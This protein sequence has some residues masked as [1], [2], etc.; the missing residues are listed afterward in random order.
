MKLLVLALIDTEY[1][2]LLRKMNAQFA[3]LR[4]RLPHTRCYIIGDGKPEQMRG[5][6]FTY[7]HA[8][9]LEDKIACCYNLSESL[10]PDLVYF[11]YPGAYE[12]LLRYVSAFPNVVFEHNTIEGKEYTGISKDREL[13]LGPQIISAAAGVI[14][15][16]REIAEYERERSRPDLPIFVLPNSLDT[17]PEEE[18]DERPP[19][20]PGMALHMIMAAR[21]DSWHGVERIIEGIAQS[22]TRSK[23]VLHLVG[24][25]PALAKYHR[26]V[27]EH[28][29]SKQVIFHG[30]LD[31]A[32]L[33]KIYAQCHLAFGAIA[34]ARK[35]LRE[36]CAIKAREYCAM[37][38]PFVLAGSD[39]DFQMDLPFVH[40][41]PNDDAPVVM[42]D[43]YTFALE[44]LS[45]PAA[46]HA[47]RAFAQKRLTWD[48]RSEDW[49]NFLRSVA[50]TAAKKITSP[51]L[52][53]LFSIVIPCY[54]QAHFLSEAVAS[55]HAQNF[56]DL[57]VIIVNDGSPDNTSEVARQ[58]MA[59]Y[60]DMVIRVLEQEN[61]G[62]SEARNS[63]IRE[64]KA[65]WILCVDSD[66][67][68]A[69]GF[70]VA[71][72]AAIDETPQ[73]SALGGMLREFGA[74][75]SDWRY[76]LFKGSLSFSNSLPASV[77]FRRSLWEAVGGYDPSNP[78]GLE[79]W[80][81][82]LKSMVF[83]WLPR[84]LSK[85]QYWYRIHHKTS[86]FDKVK[87]HWN[88]V[89]AL[90][91]TML[92]GNYSS[93]TVLAAHTILLNMSDANQQRIKAK[94]ER[95]PE[96][97]LPWFWLG[98]YHE[99]QNE[100]EAALSC[101]LR[102]QHLD[103]MALPHP[104]GPELQ[105]QIHYRLYGLYL[106]MNFGKKAQLSR[107][108]CEELKPELKAPLAE[109]D[110]IIALATSAQKATKRV[111]LMGEFFWPSLG[112]IETFLEH[113][114][115]YL[116]QNGYE[117][118]VATRTRPG[119]QSLEHRGMRIHEFPHYMNL[120]SGL[121]GGL[122][123]FDCLLR[124]CGFSHVI[125]LSHIDPWSMYLC[126]MPHP[127]PK[128]IFLP[129]LQNYKDFIKDQSLAE[130]VRLI[131]QA[132]HVC[133][134]MES[135]LDRQLLEL[136]GIKSHFVPHMVPAL[137]SGYQF[138]KSFGLAADI[139]LF[140]NV[141]NFWP[142]KNHLGLIKTLKT[143]QGDWRLVMIGSPHD[144]RCLA[145]VQKAIEGD[146]RFML[147]ERQPRDVTAA[148][149]READTVLLGSWYEGCPLTILEAMS[150]GTP[151]LATPEC[152]S[153]VDQAGG[154]VANLERFPLLLTEIV[155]DESVKAA[156][157]QLG[158]RHWKAC[159]SPEAVLPAFIDLLE[160]DGAHMPDLRMPPQ[161]RAENMALWSGV[162]D[163]TA[164]NYGI[165]L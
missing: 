86:M 157:G 50:A 163:R 64:A 138:R 22:A 161:L 75:D 43:V 3:A 59:T 143:L 144:S 112:G 142:F 6:D 147:L 85:P 107:D 28:G 63:G 106:S 23:F 109:Q 8:T 101:Y 26:L 139:P 9:D 77:V 129:L 135:S 73:I 72:T 145:Q 14:G 2:Q 25:G 153:V 19:L 127:K 54:N 87:E 92:G 160:N 152:G 156:L 165:F 52:G 141:A 130:M 71:A 124:Q 99:G 12:P 48:G 81:F 137:E 94:C 27:R 76:T 78:W 96:L 103:A 20:S 132:S 126:A 39:P 38:L 56:P 162:R 110:R 128:V 16:T 159:F 151:W 158:K 97:P 155:N 146:S 66:D 111:L 140:L 133:R 60:P 33:Q 150:V 7:I 89:Q 61:M 100:K 55:V 32:E 90:H 57:E 118:H 62:L 35:G 29:L 84:P 131:G 45:N 18:P 30:W 15:V 80:H 105:W 116:L 31:P 93:E 40:I 117:V 42:E 51:P 4:R 134:I 1:P 136:A 70:L 108:A 37:G 125:C 13:A 49:V 67:K 68:L 154:F 149:I 121:L 10:R 69:E 148:A 46:N 24:G 21:F 47:I 34:I 82:W 79:D 91:Q 102:A 36:A 122:D 164:F 58:L 65:P 113:L 123:D 120:Q 44:S 17:V 115:D 11:R 98:L 41:I 119:R 83:G 74:R 104:G 5:Y 95:F 114:G 88:E 53:P